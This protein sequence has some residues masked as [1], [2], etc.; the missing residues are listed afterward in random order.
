MDEFPNPEDE[1]E[2]MYAEELEVLREIEEAEAKKSTTQSTP[3]SEIN[4]QI[5]DQKSQTVT[6][7]K[8]VTI[9]SQQ[10]STQLTQQGLTNNH[11]GTKD[12]VVKNLFGTRSNGLQSSTVVN[13]SSCN[14]STSF[15]PVVKNLFGTKSNGLQSTTVVNGSSSNASTSFD[16]SKKRSINQIEC[17]IPSTSK[18]TIDLDSD[19]Y[20]SHDRKKPRWDQPE[21]V[22]K[23]ILERRNNL[24]RKESKNGGS[25]SRKKKVNSITKR[26]P[27]H[28]F[29]AV[30]RYTDG[31]RF[32]V[33]VCD[34]SMQSIKVDRSKSKNLFKSFSQLKEEAENILEKNREKAL[35]KPLVSARKENS[36]S[37]LW[38]DKYKPTRYLELLS[39]ESVNRSLL[40]WLKLWDKVVFDKDTIMRPNKPAPVTKFKNK[41]KKED[42][43]PDLDKNGFPTQRIALL[44]GPPGLGKTTLAHISARHA[45]YSIVEL[46]ASDDRGPEA[47]REA[48]LSSTQMKAVI[49][50]EK[51]PNC[52]VLDEIDGAPAA[53]IELLLKFIH[54]KLAPKGKKDKVVK[55][56]LGCKRPIICICNDLYAPSLRPL[57]QMALVLNVPEISSS[58]LVERLSEI[59]RKEGLNINGRL[60]LEL[61]HKSGCDIRACLGIL[62]YT[63]GRSNMLKDLTLG[64]KETRKGL[65]DCWKELMRIPTD[66][67]GSLPDSERAKKVMTI[68]HQGESERLAQGIFHN[69][70]NN[71]RTKLSTVSKSLDWFE[72]YDIMNRAVMEHQSWML[73]PY[74]NFA[75]I[76]WHLGLASPQM[77]KISF[78]STTFEVNQKIERNQ[79]VLS[80]IKK[81]SKLDKNAL[82]TEVLP[83]LP[84]LLCPQLRSV[85]AQLYSNKEKEELRRLVDTMLDF[86]LTFTQIKK[87]EGGYQ[88][89]LDPNIWDIGV[90]PQCNSHKSLSHAVK[91]IVIQELEVTRLQRA[92]IASGEPTNQNPSAQKSIES[93]LKSGASKSG[94][95]SQASQSSDNV[96]SH[97]RTLN[98]VQI[99]PVAEKKCRNFFRAFQQAGQEKLK[100]KQAKEKELGIVSSK[101]ISMAEQE[102][103]NLKDK[104]QLFRTDI[105]YIFKEGYSNAVRRTVLMKDLLK[106]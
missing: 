66:R 39:D 74:T 26:V 65:F 51:R 3:Q 94:S 48:L 98:P 36:S 37:Q 11:N 92:A 18:G 53:S 73:M 99:E 20:G 32:Y 41:F 79:A 101:K 13:G 29:V 67:R 5:Q 45:G 19:I 97:L 68:V 102:K 75:F 105:T 28:N 96:P 87:P 43:V 62:Q 25:T 22:M 49:D 95:A 52:L 60:L 40:Y 16:N 17:D 72:Y 78:P 9:D 47:F 46:N 2:L 44:T 35:L 81:K 93:R 76:A 21:E 23:L 42:L 10:G 90:F 106:K 88:Y 54:G 82:V 56:N 63:G 57:R 84:D 70:P 7:G 50:E 55:N 12:P 1:Y 33:K 15:D 27:M 77:P 86:G 100:A 30:T 8:N 69:Y 58:N 64:L 80:L 14:A 83:Y 59:A 34:R 89:Y 61:V 31:E 4:Q 24:H 104:M 71:C 6:T 91:Q 85:N 38:V 103:Q